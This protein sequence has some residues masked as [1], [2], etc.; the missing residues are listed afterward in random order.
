MNTNDKTLADVQPGGR[1]RL[2]DQAERA[3]FEAWAHAQSYRGGNIMADRD[4][5]HP[6]VYA[7]PIAQLTWK[8]WKA[9][10]SAQPSPGGQ[11]VRELLAAEFDK[12]EVTAAAARRLRN[13]NETAVEAA[14]L[15]VIAA[16][17]PVEA[18]PQG[19][20]AC[21]RT[22]IRQNDEGRN[23]CCPD[24][25]LG[26]AC[27]G[28]TRQPVG[29]PVAVEVPQGAIIN[30]AAFADRLEH[31]YQFECPAGPLANCTDYVEFR[32]C[33]DFLAQWASSLP[34]LYA[35]TPAQAVDLERFRPA[36]MTALGLSSPYGLERETLNELLDLIDSQVVGNG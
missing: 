8:S 26:R 32:R 1:V 23:I 9:A 16:R 11:D 17:Q 21:D 19:C 7:D 24:C 28:D 3:R 13:H 2:G 6:D 30:G 25:D 12:N 34:P 15:R 5:V 36:V 35:A 14:A 18:A 31:D 20:D 4:A 22:G 10:L 29:E 33:F 27:A